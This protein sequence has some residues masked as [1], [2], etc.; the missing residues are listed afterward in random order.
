[1]ISM[2]AIQSVWDWRYRQIPIAITLAGGVMGLL[3]SMMRER[4]LM[5]LC[6]G[7]VPGLVCLG[8]GWITRE[9]IGYGDGFLL[10]AM[11][12]YKSLEDI[13]GIIV[14]ASSLA[15]ILGMVLII[16]CKKKGKDQIPF[17]PFLLVGSVVYMMLQQGAE[18]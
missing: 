18:L 10:C 8:L 3:L 14:L 5:D 9:A 16:L 1:M 13:V 7:L 4:S 11:G 15:G 2:L 12:M 6:M 17:V